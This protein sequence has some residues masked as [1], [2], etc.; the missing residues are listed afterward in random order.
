MMRQ[1][2]V[3][4]VSVAVILLALAPLVLAS[5]LRAQS[6][7][8]A[9]RLSPNT[10]FYVQ[11]R[12]KAF[13]SDAEK[14]N[15]VLQL[16]EDPALAPVWAMVASRIQNDA[17][18][19]GS[20]PLA[21]IWPDAISFLD[22]SMVVG[23]ATYPGAAKAPSA[24]ASKPA[25]T[26]LATFAVYDATGKTDL[27]QKWKALSDVAR[28]TPVDVT[29]YDFGG[30][31]VEVRTAGKDVSYT[32]QA[33]NYFLF[34]DQ[35][36]IIEDLITRF[37]GSG[38]PSTSVE[39]T[40]GYAEMRKFIGSDA[41]LEYFGRI[42]DAKQLNLPESS[43]KAMEQVAS[44][45]HL[46]KIHVAGGGISFSGEATRFRGAVLGDT[47]PDGLFDL[48]GPSKAAF[49]T[50]EIVNGSSTFS[51]SR[52]NLPATYEL[53]RGTVIASLNPQQ[54][55]GVTA[56]EAMGQGYIGM[57][58][59]DALGL[60]TGEV[61]SVSTY[62]D[63]GEALQLYAVAIQKPDSVL[64]VL[65]AVAAKMIVAEDSSGSATFL[66]LA[67][68]YKDPKTG[69]QRRKFYYLAVTPQ[70]MLA[71]PR[72]A[73]LREA[74]NRL[75]AT[76][77]DPPSGGIFAN[78]EYLRMRALLPEKLSGLSGS[79]FTQ[80]PWDK[81]LDNLA[82][83]LNQAAAQSKN[84]QPPDTSWIKLLKPDVINQHLHLSVGGWWKDPSG[85][86]FDSYIQ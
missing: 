85:V 46:E 30:T 58:I 65:R 38:H 80:I 79:D 81:L 60:F 84:S 5:G 39:Q 50:Q 51:M 41:A 40:P 78:P 71:A 59:P 34:S 42:P 54:A 75:N 18:K 49:Q 43:E 6:A 45:L 31:S 62:S 19:P 29:K 72:K 11:W 1:N 86:Y 26:R 15:H 82:E 24:D 35:K 32:A 22:N 77:A 61:A 68:P 73:M 64:R 69:T 70:M 37:G 8:I 44:N 83:Q 14:Q 3:R 36:A 52:F 12:G 17:G 67:Y 28:K 55:A 63:N 23:F 53:I 57:S 27:I 56:L 33:A 7:P 74:M 20:V 48:A 4:R 13:L 9:P 66:D 76:T 25:P 21:V 10:F 2:A 47:S 16:L